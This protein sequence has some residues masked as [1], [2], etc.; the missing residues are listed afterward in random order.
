M[1][2]VLRLL[3]DTHA[4]IWWLAGDE[5]LSLRA[6]EAIAD[7]TNLIAVSAASAM[8]I[9]TKFR[10]GK[11]PNAAYLAQDFEAIIASQGFTELPISI[12]HA[13]LAGELNISHKDPFDRFLIAQAQAEG[14][15]LISNEQVFD[16]FAVQ[17]LW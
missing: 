1:E 13:R 14:M 10:I 5:A 3:L 6:R 8:E 4:L 2:Y 16:S 11:L 9:A 17:R 15:M 12:R 7:E